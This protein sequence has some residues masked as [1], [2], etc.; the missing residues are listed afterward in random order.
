M[1]GNEGV[2][3]AILYSAFSLPEYSFKFFVMPW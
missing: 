3:E 2:V 1:D